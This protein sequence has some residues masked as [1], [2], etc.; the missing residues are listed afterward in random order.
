MRFRVRCRWGFSGV[1]S[2]TFSG[3]FSETTASETTLGGTSGFSGDSHDELEM[4]GPAAMTSLVAWSLYLVKLSL[5][6]LPSLVTSSLKSADP[7]QLF[8]GLRSSSGTPG[9]E[10][11]TWRLKVS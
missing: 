3:T 5:K 7:V 10:V 1:F 6:S 4:T 8:F 9:Q 11:G 2:G